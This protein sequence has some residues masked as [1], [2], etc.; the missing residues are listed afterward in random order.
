MKTSNQIIP[1]TFQDENEVRVSIIEGEPWFVATDVCKILGYVNAPD[2]IKKHCRLDGIVKRYIIDSLNRSQET[3]LINEGNLYRLIIKSKKPEAQKF[4]SWVCDEVLPQIRKTGSYGIVGKQSAELENL[5]NAMF[6]EFKEEMSKEFVTMEEY[7]DQI[8]DIFN[9]AI[10]TEK[11]IKAVES[12]FRD[13]SEL[14][15]EQD[16]SVVYVML[17]RQTEEYKIGQSAKARTRQK[18]FQQVEPNIEI[19][20]TIPVASQRMANYLEKMLHEKFNYCHSHGEWYKLKPTDL[21]M[22]KMIA[23]VLV[24]AQ[25]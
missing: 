24:E 8:N 4:E 20:L 17:N 16:T 10:N 18:Q 3:S 2:A 23:E 15:V 19:V 12:R 9:H 1:F 14:L 21:D 6:A 22:I 11:R 5:M 25:F 13:F 7:D